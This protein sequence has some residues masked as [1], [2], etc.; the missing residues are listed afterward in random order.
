MQRSRN[1]SLD[2]NGFVTLL[3]SNRKR[4]L[5]KTKN[6]ASEGIR[7]RLVEEEKKGCQL[8]QTLNLF[9]NRFFRYRLFLSIVRGGG[10]GGE[11]EQRVESFD[12]CSGMFHISRTDRESDLQVSCRPFLMRGAE[13]TDFHIGINSERSRSSEDDHLYSGDD[14]T[15][16][17]WWG[18]RAD[19]RAWT[20]YSNELTTVLFLDFTL[21]DS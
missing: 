1:T 12:S 19:D 11:D 21:L 17:D 10:E 20:C 2:Y 3:F 6:F 5:E 8:T 14:V 18:S 4:L 16:C 15:T 13:R 9:R 7:N